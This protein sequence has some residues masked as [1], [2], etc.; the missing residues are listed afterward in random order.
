[1]PRIPRIAH[2]HFWTEWG[3]E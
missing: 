3:T 2:F 1:M